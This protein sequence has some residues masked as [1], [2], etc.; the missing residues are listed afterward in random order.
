MGAPRLWM[1]R[2]PPRHGSWRRL[3]QELSVCSDWL[4][5][6]PDGHAPEGVTGHAPA[7][8]TQT[9]AHPGPRTIPMSKAIERALQV[10]STSPRRSRV[11]SAKSPP[12][13]DGGSPPDPNLPCPSTPQKIAPRYCSY[14]LNSL[15]GFHSLY[16]SRHSLCGLRSVYAF[17]SLLRFR[18]FPMRVSAFPIRAS[19]LIRVS[20][21]TRGK[22]LIGAKI[23][24][25]V[26]F[27]I[28]ASAFPMRV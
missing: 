7:T 9:Q 4:F 6:C 21:P 26:P 11:E 28:R 5:P 3:L 27:P 25:R 18:H 20:F 17:Q 23:L 22:I 15:Y 8:Q 2:T 12:I 10:P 14:G 24:I 16:G 13:P 19:F 1:M